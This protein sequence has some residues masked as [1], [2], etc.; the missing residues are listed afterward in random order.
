M[1]SLIRLSNILTLSGFS[2]CKRSFMAFK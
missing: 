1:Y 2:F